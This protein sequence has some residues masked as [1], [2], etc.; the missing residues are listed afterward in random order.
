MRLPRLTPGFPVD[1]WA[2]ALVGALERLLGTVT[3]TVTLTAGATT[4]TLTDA[5]ITPSSHISLMPTT[6][7]AGAENWHIPPATITNGSAV[8]THANAATVDRTFL[9]RVG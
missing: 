7:N 6:A 5:A 2:N 1:R 9:Y 8:I 3:G 4:T